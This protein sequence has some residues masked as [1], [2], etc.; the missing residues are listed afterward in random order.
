ML[1]SLPSFKNFA[2]FFSFASLDADFCT[3]AWEVDG[4][5]IGA[6]SDGPAGAAGMGKSIAFSKISGRSGAGDRSS[7]Q[8]IC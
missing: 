8:V 3:G 6:G 2:I 1:H 7:I 4:A 5:G